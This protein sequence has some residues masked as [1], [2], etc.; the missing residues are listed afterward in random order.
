MTIVAWDQSTGAIYDTCVQIV[1]V[2][3]PPLY[4]PLFTAPV[5]AV[6]AAA[7]II[8]AAVLLRRRAAGTP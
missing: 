6:L 8:A 3:E 4:V 7:L 1:E 5:L 2:V